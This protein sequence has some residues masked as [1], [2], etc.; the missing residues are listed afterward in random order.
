[1]WYTFNFGCIAT[2][3]SMPDTLTHSFI[4]VYGIEYLYKL[5]TLKN[6]RYDLSFIVFW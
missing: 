2:P 5:T 6:S 3:T 4:L 1:M